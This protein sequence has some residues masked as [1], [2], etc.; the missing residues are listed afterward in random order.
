MRKILFLDIDGVLNSRFWYRNPIRKFLKEQNINRWNLFWLSLFCRIKRLD[1]VLSSSWRYG[2]TEN[3]EVREVYALSSDKLFKRYGLNIIGRTC[4]GSTELKNK[5]E[6]TYNSDLKP[7][8]APYYRGT[9]ILDY[10]EKH[11]LDIRDCL[12]V[13]DDIFDI[14]CYD[15]LKSI[16]IRTSFY[17]L[18]GGFQPSHF[19]KNIFHH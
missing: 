10:I 4:L 14:V 7:F 12:I 15:C 3:G 11:D 9:Q 17:K 13:D 2:W 19:F 5:Y 18:F 8:D 16:T 6:I 1:I